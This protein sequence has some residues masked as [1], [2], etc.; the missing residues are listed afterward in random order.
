MLKICN[1]IYT[2]RFLTFSSI[3]HPKINTTNQLLK[4]NFKL[5]VKSETFIKFNT[6]SQLIVCYQCVI[7]ITIITTVCLLWIFFIQWFLSPDLFHIFLIS[8]ICFL[9]NFFSC[10][11][12]CRIWLLFFQYHVK[13][14]F[15][16]SGLFNN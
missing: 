2:S 3:G 14:K 7:L 11:C 5:F 16:L 15:K 6:S 9:F 8:L 1:N 12:C 10:Y 13:L 4:V